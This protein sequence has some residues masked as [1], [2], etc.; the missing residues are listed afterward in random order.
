MKF[1]IKDKQ[2]GFVLKNGV[3][4]KMI[5]AGMYHFSQMAGYA[6]AV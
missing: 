2:A 5:T 1:I 4:Q 6:V 3:F